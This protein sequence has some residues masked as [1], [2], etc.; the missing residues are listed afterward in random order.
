MANQI[1]DKELK[2]KWPNVTGNT[3]GTT[4]TEGRKLHLKIQHK[5]LVPKRLK[6]G[7]NG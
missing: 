5:S 3:A 2:R 6:V 1:G 4:K 7:L